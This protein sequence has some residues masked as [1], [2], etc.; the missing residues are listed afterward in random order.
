[1]IVHCTESLGKS[2][3][4]ISVALKGLSCGL[5]SVGESQ[6]V[7][8]LNDGRTQGAEE[9]WGW[10]DYPRVELLRKS[11]LKTLCS[12]GKGEADDFPGLG[13][14]DTILHTHG[15][16]TQLSVMVPRLARQ[17]D[18]PWV[19]S[20]HGM[21]DPWALRQSSFKKRVARV[22]FED[23]HLRG[24]SALH[25][26]CEEEASAIRELGLTNPIAV[27]PNGVDLPGG[28]EASKPAKAPGA[29]GKSLLFLGRI[30]P[31]KGLRD[32]LAA[33][34]RYQQQVRSG[35]WRFLVAG[36]NQDG[37]EEDLQ[38]FCDELGLPWREIPLAEWWNDSA[39]MQDGQVLFLGPAFGS[40]KDRLLREVDA[41]VLPSQSEG[42]PMAVL[43]AWAYRL[44]VLM[45]K[46]CH[47]SIGF[48]AGA[49]M[50]WK[51]G[52]E[53]LS[54]FFALSDEARLEQA[55]K[56][57]RLVEEKFT[58]GSVASQMKELYQWISEGDTNAVSPEFVS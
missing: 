9:G 19:V 3:G 31:K 28:L 56:G 35:S 27:I 21:L 41:F 22:L 49:A 25:A 1:M 34:S 8:G 37:H 2:G 54:Q 58:W 18:C 52:G 11:P 55:D 51:E 42:L 57:R 10:H 38:A 32:A 44:P 39:E 26:L 53:V 33:W 24:A 14:K 50:E 46:E 15:L 4:G 47:L 6:A 13:S 45:T 5:K 20:P 7:V 36:W 29:E 23:H 12:G 17:H 43:E 16:W 40:E 48:A 30:H